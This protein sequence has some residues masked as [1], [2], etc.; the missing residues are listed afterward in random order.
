[1]AVVN[2]KGNSSLLYNCGSAPQLGTF[3]LS[4]HKTKQSQQLNLVKMEISNDA[5]R[6]IPKAKATRPMSLYTKA[7]ARVSTFIPT[8]STTTDWEASDNKQ[9]QNIKRDTCGWEKL[10]YEI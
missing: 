3:H 6:N 2:R 4:L 1:M 7:E 10:P 5:A 9:L 8:R